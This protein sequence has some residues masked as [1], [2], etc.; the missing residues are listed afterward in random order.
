MGHLFMDDPEIKGA[1]SKNKSKG[2]TPT[3]ARRGQR[4]G[5]KD[6]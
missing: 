3:S 4:W 2:K 1:R 5:T 6:T